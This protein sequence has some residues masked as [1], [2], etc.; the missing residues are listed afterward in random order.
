MYGDFEEWV[1]GEAENIALDYVERYA[2]LDPPRPL[3]LLGWDEEFV[4]W[5]QPPRPTD[6]IVSFDPGASKRDQ[7]RAV[8]YDY[9]HDDPLRYR[10]DNEAVKR[11][12]IGG[13]D[14]RKEGH[15]PLL[16]IAAYENPKH[17]IWS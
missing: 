16:L 11:C 7:A 1:V 15:D 9:Y 6:V 14:P 4:G 12:F 5:S 8:L 13:T 10:S 17:K 3:G 2:P